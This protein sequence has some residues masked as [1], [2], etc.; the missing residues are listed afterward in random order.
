[1]GSSQWTIYEFLPYNKNTMLVTLMFTNRYSSVIL[2]IYSY[3]SVKN[4]PDKIVR[5]SKHL[6]VW[7]IEKRS[8]AD[9][10]HFTWKTKEKKNLITYKDTVIP[11][12]PHKVLKLNYQ[13]KYLVGISLCYTS[14]LCIPEEYLL[15]NQWRKLKFMDKFVLCNSTNKLYSP[16]NI[17]FKVNFQV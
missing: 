14:A 4:C 9:M 5:C 10:A 1:M 12:S 8:N 3:I 13:G 6:G 17:I 11:C 15:L 16:S 2:K 7:W